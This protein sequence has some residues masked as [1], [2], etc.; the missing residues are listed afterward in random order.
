MSRRISHHISDNQCN[1]SSPQNFWDPSMHNR[2]HQPTEHK[3]WRHSRAGSGGTLVFL[4]HNLLRKTLLIPGLPK[5]TEFWEKKMDMRLWRLA[6]EPGI[7]IAQGPRTRVFSHEVEK[8]GLI[9]SEPSLGGEL[10]VIIHR[11]T[12]DIE[13]VASSLMAGLINAIWDGLR[14]AS[15]QASLLLEP[16]DWNL[17]NPSLMVEVMLFQNPLRNSVRYEPQQEMSA[18]TF[19]VYV[20]I[21][22]YTHT[23][24]HV[25]VCA[26]THE[27]R[28][29]PYHRS[30]HYRPALL[31]NSC[32]T[33]SELY[34]C[35]V[36]M[37]R[38]V[39]QFFFF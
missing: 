33:L 39:L 23:H 37:Q 17:R 18:W 14:P 27:S 9:C 36:G 8:S 7:F 34:V 6:K 26:C 24:I 2:K 4:L 31:V 19:R 3:E 1:L 38:I 15:F 28:S 22:I 11:G 13:K 20:Y 29:P 35:S 25:C 12:S 30:F 16:N 10:L 21:Y 5:P 32:P